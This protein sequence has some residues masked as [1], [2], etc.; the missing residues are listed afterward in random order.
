MSRC[1]WRPR[2][3]PRRLPAKACL[4]QKRRTGQLGAVEIDGEAGVGVGA[5]GVVAG[6]IDE[7]AAAIAADP[8]LDLPLAGEGP[9]GQSGLEVVGQ[10]HRHAEGG[11]GDHLRRAVGVA[12]VDEIDAVVV[13]H[14]RIESRV[15]EGRAL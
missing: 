9:A 4:S 6:R 15:G 14:P 2:R 12:V 7:G 5:G 8:V 11:G 1:R 10:G 3:G 13:V